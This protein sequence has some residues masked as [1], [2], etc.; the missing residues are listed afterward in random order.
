MSKTWDGIEAATLAGGRVCIEYS[1]VADVYFAYVADAGGAYDS[2]E[3]ASA[4]EAANGAIYLAGYLEA[5]QDPGGVRPNVRG[6]RPYLR[7]VPEVE[8]RARPL[9]RSDVA[10]HTECLG[11]YTFELLTPEAEQWVYANVEDP[12]FHGHVLVVEGRFAQDLAQG[13]IDDGLAVE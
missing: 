7:L 1:E 10:V 2:A 6:E 5:E 9:E 13:M 8:E 12:M 11:L 3:A 4:K